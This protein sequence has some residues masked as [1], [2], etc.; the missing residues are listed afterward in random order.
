M[1]CPHCGKANR[2][3]ALFCASCGTSLSPRSNPAQLQPGQKLNGGRY[4]IVRP[5][6]RG[7][8]GVIYLVK[9]LET[10]DKPRALKEMLDYV[11]PAEY[12][13]AAAYQQALNKAH[14]RFEDEA[15]ILSHLSHPGIPEIIDY[16]PEN[17]SNYIVMEYV[18]GEDLSTNLTHLNEFGLVV[19]GRPYPV[20]NVVRWGAQ[21][22]KI[23]EYLEK[24]TPTPVVHHDIKPANLVLDKSSGDVRLVDFGT[25][26]A[27]LRAQAGGKV[28]LQKSSVFG[29]E[30]YAP[31]EQYLG[32]SVPKSDVYALA[33]TMYH[34]LTD[35]DPQ[36]HPFT[37]PWPTWLDDGLKKA[38]SRAVESDV[39]KRAT[40]GELRQV[41][42][43]WKT[44]P[45]P[46]KA[47]PKPANFRVILTHVPDA[48]IA[49]VIQALRATLSLTEQQATITAYSAP[50]TVVQ[51][52]PYAD[53]TKVVSQLKA[54]G[55]SV[56]LVDVD[57]SH[58]ASLADGALR[59]ELDAEGQVR[60]IVATRLGSD[61]RCHCFKCG[62]DWTSR[63]AAGAPPP[64]ICPHCKSDSWSLHR[65]FK[66]RVCGHEFVHG[67]LRY[68]PTSLFPACPACGA[69]DWL[70]RQ[71]PR[72]RITTTTIDLGTVRLSKGASVVLK[73]ANGG[74]GV[75]RGV[76]RC[77][78]PWLRVEKRFTGNAAITL[79][80][81]TGC[82]TG[83]T[84]Y[85][86]CIDLVTNGGVG[87]VT[88]KFY[89]QSPERLSVSPLVLDLGQVGA[90][91]VTGM[92]QITNLGGGRLEGSVTAPAPWLR[93][94]RTSVAGNAVDLSVIADP[95]E[96]L[97]G[98]AQDAFIRIVTNG[99]DT[100]ISVRA[101]A[102]PATLTL[103]PSSLD[104]GAV[105]L[106]EK[107]SLTLRAL[108]TGAGRLECR[109]ADSPKWIGLSQTRW[110]E[111][112]WE[113]TLKVDGRHLSDGAER[114]GLIRILSNGGEARVP[115]R[116]VAMGVTLA[117]EP[118]SVDFGT[119]LVG[120]KANRQLELTNREAGELQG[121]IRSSPSWLCLEPRQFSGNN[122]G[123]TASLATKGLSPGQYTDSIEIES[124]G[125]NASISVR[126]QLSAESRVAHTA[127]QVLRRLQNPSQGAS[128]TSATHS[129]SVSAK[130]SS[131]IRNLLL[132]ALALIIAIGF[133]CLA[134]L[135]SELPMPVTS[136]RATIGAV[137]DAA[138]ANATVLGAET[139]TTVATPVPPF[140][141]GTQVKL[142][143]EDGDSITA[144]QVA[145]SCEPILAL[146]QLPTDMDARILDAVCYNWERGVH[147]YQVLLA[148]GT[149]CWIQGADLLRADEHTPEAT[150]TP[151]LTEMAQP[152]P[153][154]QPTD[155]LQATPTLVSLS[156]GLDR[157]IA[158][159]PGPGV[160][161]QYADPT[162]L[163][164]DR[165]I[166]ENPCCQGILQLGRGGSV[167]AAFV[168]NVA[169]DGEGPDLQLF[170]ESARDDFVLVEVSADGRDWR[171]Y[172]RVSESPDGFD[173]AML[174]L[175]EVVFVRITD[176]Q[177][178]TSTGAELDA[179][180]AL[181]SEL[182]VADELP[183]LADAV[184]REDLSLREGPDK[185]MAEVGRAVAG[186]LLS[187][188]RRTKA[189]DWV[190]VETLSGKQGWC[191]VTDLELNVTLSGVPLVAAPS[192]PSPTA[193]PLASP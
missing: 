126:L 117:V 3:G 108:N 161:K 159:N 128:S 64:N 71:S 80:V 176:L 167:L 103:S 75:L 82:L 55:V 181:H 8:M 122:A 136:R 72:L 22:C 16:F 130:K 18:E 141:A 4:E 12:P 121:V 180:L 49:H 109:I 54:A 7:G 35:D 149:T 97:A 69:T 30:G 36:Q 163:L 118:Q 138:T 191:Y 66:C 62:H 102:L 111:N 70:T 119:Q 140:P 185:L 74:T 151:H 184:A 164:G 92:V 53:A 165:D 48:R 86:G 142:V 65:I 26:K 39:A 46:K 137:H 10:F 91:Q 41:L 139:P 1:Q 143:A 99:G 134:L 166:V 175:D 57:E 90:E 186:S 67:D 37:Y 105:P 124:N 25:A 188:K 43:K 33:A 168:D 42:E 192:A 31:P 23:L 21:V 162:A 112:N 45:L 60:N 73:L 182:S 14:Q 50:T 171:S 19:A 172:P 174:G 17:G 106:R 179:V 146:G 157:V 58:S 150:D 154:P 76:I 51:K 178:G 29:T 38:L 115:V 129:A 78:E 2:T 152:T 94:S 5:L 61:K 85:Q 87:K 173:L 88:V 32:Q 28:G 20:E 169:M 79:P 95:A 123:L 147:F 177:P 113:L 156:G 100:T 77:Q 63:R 84:H 158:Y 160:K 44:K 9:D 131:K 101:D 183:E 148:D 120:S 56:M 155:S 47:P 132:P 52:V 144:W 170:G 68:P 104:F 107:R 114:T 96:M 110:S 135:G 6:S 93:L 40:A 193:A 13:G 127:R 27:R 59:H 89:A 153:A 98:Q 133:V 190:E 81:D 83:E 15:R 116:A 145:G 125:G 11:D 189:S 34:L 24:Q 187:I